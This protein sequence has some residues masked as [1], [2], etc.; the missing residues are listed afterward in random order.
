MRGEDS[1][2]HMK[3]EAFC[4]HRSHGE[5]GDHRQGLLLEADHNKLWVVGD[6]R[7]HEWVVGQI[8]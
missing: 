7:S 6:D 4:S 8:L 2:N 5:E 3:L 1:G